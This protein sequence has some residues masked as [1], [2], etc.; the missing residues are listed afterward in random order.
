[1]KFWKYHG[2]GNDFILIY[3]Q[4]GRLTPTA[5]GAARMC[6]RHYGIGGDGILLLSPASDADARMRIFN[7]DGSEA[8]MCGNG[9]RCAAK[10]LYDHSIIKSKKMRIST[11][12]GVKN[13]ECIVKEGAVSEVIVDMG[14]AV[15]DC[16]K[17]PAKFDG[18][19]IDKII[20]IDGRKVK[21]TAVSMGNPHFVTFDDFTTEEK[22]ILGPLLE[23]HSMFPKRTNVEFATVERDDIKVEVFERGAGWTLGCGTGACATTVAAAITRRVEFD[24]EIRVKLPGGSLI[25]VVPKT[26]TSILMRGPA[27]C[28]YEGNFNWSD[29]DDA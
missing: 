11:L 20:E 12:A 22:R 16:K 23:K 8:E 9:I 14:Q 10:Y 5:S 18:E 24:K 1:M 26:L 29:F 19:F 3:D 6:D 2:I 17:I 15:L 25:I 13:V 4:T 21:G 28:V 7:A 27:V